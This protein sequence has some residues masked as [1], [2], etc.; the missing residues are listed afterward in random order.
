MIKNKKSFYIILLAGLLAFVGISIVV[1]PV[2]AQSS[3]KTETVEKGSFPESLD[4]IAI[5]SNDQPHIAYRD[6]NNKSLK[7]A[8]LDESTNTWNIQTVDK[9]GNVG[10]N[11]SLELDSDDDPHITYINLTSEGNH[12]KYASFDGNSWNI[13]TVTG[14]ETGGYN[15]L[16]LDSSDIPHIAFLSPLDQPPNDNNLKYGVLNKSTDTWDIQIIENRTFLT[17]YL[18]LD[19]SGNPHIVY[20]SFNGTLRYASLIGGSWD[21]ETVNNESLGGKPSLAI[22]SNDQPHIA[23]YNYSSKAGLKY[24]VLS[25]STNSWDT[26]IVDNKSKLVR[27]LGAVTY[28]LPSRKLF[29]TFVSIELDN[30]DRPHIAYPNYTLSGPQIEF[31]RNALKYASFDGN[32]WN[33]EIADGN[34]TNIGGEAALALDSNNNPHIAYWNITTFSSVKYATKKTKTGTH[35]LNVNVGLASPGGSTTINI[36]AENVGGISISGIPDNWTIQNNQGGGG[37]FSKNDPDGDG[38]IEEAGWAFTAKGEKT[39][40]ITLNISSSAEKRDY[41]LTVKAQN[42]GE[43]TKTITVSVGESII[44]QYDLNN[45]GNIEGNEV[46]TSIRDFLFNNKITGT[47]VRKIIKNFL[48]N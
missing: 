16:A 3:W 9:N 30:K 18:E 19:S 2:F 24:A 25:Q 8:V 29:D 40:S 20:N 27:D 14:E 12:L 38:N 36:N 42:G 21:T 45:N 35:N 22:D 10:R 26:E 47:Q 23:F 11:P 44:D 15:S 31:E 33:T 4:A 17:S 48:F 41:Q 28:K 7:Y 6:D 5:D 43:Q 39:T 1:Q 37:I 46:R 32:S 34:G 13:Q